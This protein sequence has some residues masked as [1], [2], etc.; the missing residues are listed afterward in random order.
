MDVQVHYGCT[1]YS[2][3][4]NELVGNDLQVSD[5]LCKP[6]SLTFP[7]SIF[8]VF[9]LIPG[10]S[11]W[12]NQHQE[13]LQDSREI[14]ERGELGDKDAVSSSVCMFV[15]CSMWLG[16]LGSEAN[17]LQYTCQSSFIYYDTRNA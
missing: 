16:S 4:S 11:C 12:V 9:L 14:G 13:Q 1:S 8:H 15:L 3:H 17:K 5:S 10:S 7:H 2:R 6:Y